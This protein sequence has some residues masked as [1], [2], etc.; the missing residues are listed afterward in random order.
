MKR[1]QEMTPQQ[2]RLEF[3]V[4]CIESLA[5]RLNCPQKDI[6]LRMARAGIPQYFIRHDDPLH[7][8]SIDYVM[9][10][11]QEAIMRSEMKGGKAC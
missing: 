1:I 4:Y 5:N 3:T 11:L 8:Q 9:D 2:Q 7:T 10:E 6:Y